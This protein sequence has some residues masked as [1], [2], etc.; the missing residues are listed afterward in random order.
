MGNRNKS[1]RN[2]CAVRRTRLVTPDH[3]PLPEGRPR[4]R[5]AQIVQ[6]S[7]TRGPARCLVRGYRPAKGSLLLIASD[8]RGIAHATTDFT[9]NFTAMA[10]TFHRV[11][12]GRLLVAPEQ[13]TWLAHFGDPAAAQPNT[14]THVEM[15]WDGTRYLSGTEHRLTADQAGELTTDLVLEPVPQVLDSLRAAA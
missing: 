5:M 3:S 2:C 4:Y 8:L 15:H 11:W 7:T 14:F 6:W 13:I 9:D 10:E 1:T 12:R